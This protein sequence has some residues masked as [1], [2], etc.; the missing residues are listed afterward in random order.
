MTAPTPES[1]LAAMPLR[2]RQAVE[3]VRAARAAEARE[4]AKEADSGEAK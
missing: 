2:L 3:R 4:L 1:R